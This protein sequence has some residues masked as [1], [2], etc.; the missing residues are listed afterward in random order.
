MGTLEFPEGLE[1]IGAGAFANCRSLEDSFSLKV[2]KIL[3]GNLLGQMMVEPFKTAMASTVSFVKEQCHH[4]FTNKF[5]M[6]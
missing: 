4:M 5:L 6:A 1:S 3:D 2:S